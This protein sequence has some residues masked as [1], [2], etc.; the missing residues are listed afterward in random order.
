MT[1]V[2]IGNDDNSPETLMRKSRGIISETE[3]QEMIGKAE[4]IKE[5]FYRLRS[6][7]LISLLK[8]VGKRR[9]EIP[10]LLR[11]DVTNETVN[12]EPVYSFRFTLEKKIRHF[13][14]CQNCLTKGKPTRNSSTANF[15]KKCGVSIE[16][17]P[18]LSTHKQAYSLKNIKLSDPLAHYITE[19]LE[20][21][22]GLNPIPLFLF[23]AT[24]NIFGTMIILENE[25][26]KGRQIYNL[27]HA[28]NPNAWTHLFRDSVGGSLAK[29][30]NSLTGLFTI[31]NRLDLENLETARCYVKR[32]AGETITATA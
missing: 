22:D 12:M 2:R 14:L 3:F 23:P 27:I 7:A 21:L 1:R 10:K 20:F 11:K 19:Y 24:K 29:A 17:N 16:L 31:M 28:L 18:I 13:K 25:G 15:C 8:R 5:R 30:D 4:T 6:L 32:F 9:G 26:L